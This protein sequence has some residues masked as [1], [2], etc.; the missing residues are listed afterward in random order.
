[1]EKKKFLLLFCGNS[2]IKEVVARLK[3]HHK[4]SAATFAKMALFVSNLRAIQTALGKLMTKIYF[5][6]KLR[7]NLR[8]LVFVKENSKEYLVF[9]NFENQKHHSS[10]KFIM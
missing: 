6:F 2:A 10:D 8:N 4:L 1:M 3:R 7:G 9:E 5:C